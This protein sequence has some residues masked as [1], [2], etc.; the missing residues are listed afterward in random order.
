MKRF[1]IILS[2][3]SILISN[4]FAHKL[5][6]FAYTENGKIFISTYFVD[7][8]PCKNCT[9]A[10]YKDNN[11]ILNA[12]TDNNGEFSTDMKWKE[13]IKIVVEETLGHKGEFVLEGDTPADSKESTSIKTTE[14]YNKEMLQ[15]LIDEEL[16]KKLK[17]IKIYIGIATLLGVFGILRLFKKK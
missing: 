16:D 8:T 13:P 10:L 6:I 1:F 15:K 3:L 12:K 2:F 17:Y 7:G 11:K 14:S 9:I 5:N 4:S